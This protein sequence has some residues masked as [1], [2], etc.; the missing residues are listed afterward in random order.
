MKTKSLE[1]I[2]AIDELNDRNKAIQ[3]PLK[4]ILTD[5]NIEVLI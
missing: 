5:L 2:K 4:D 1:L 3:N